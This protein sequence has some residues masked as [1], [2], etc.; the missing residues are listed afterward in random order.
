M[1]LIF[2]ESCEIQIVYENCGNNIQVGYFLGAQPEGKE[3]DCKEPHSGTAEQILNPTGLHA[4]TASF[5][6]VF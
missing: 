4:K 5:D 2:N 6:A 3:N 1:S